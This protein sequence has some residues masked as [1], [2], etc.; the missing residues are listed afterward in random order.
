MAQINPRQSV[1][2]SGQPFYQAALKST[3]IYALATFIARAASFFLFPVYT[4][5]LSPADYGVLELLELSLY[6]WGQL[7]GM[8]VAAAFV[9][10][11]SNAPTREAQRVALASAYW[12]AVLIGAISFGLG[13]V[14]SPWLSALVFGT[15]A[16]AYGFRLAFGAFAATLPTDVAL[17]W[18]RARDRAVHYL[19]FSVV[20]L[21]VSAALAIY[22]L[23]AWRW[24]YKAVLWGNLLASVGLSLGASFYLLGVGGSPWRFRW[25]E[26]GRL[27]SYGVPLGIGGVGMLIVHYGDRFFLRQYVSLDVIGV[28]ALAY[29]LGMLVAYV[30]MPFNI[31]WQ[32]RM[33]AIVKRPDGE[34]IY[35][36][37]LTYLALVL[38]A[39]VVLLSAFARPGLRVLAGR[40]FWQAAD[41]VPFIALA[42][43]VRALG[44][45]V[46]SALLIAGSTTREAAVVW[47]S[48]LVCLA[49]Y[50]LLIPR[51]EVWGAV[52]ATG[53]AFV[54][55]LVLGFWQAQRVRPFA[56][57][58]YR[59][60]LIFLSAVPT[61]L[62]SALI[63]PRSFAEQLWLGGLL[64]LSFPAVLFLARFPTAE[65]QLWLRNVM[66]RIWEKLGRGGASDQVD[67]C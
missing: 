13:W 42:Y 30:H 5:F 50:A 27:A 2:Q 45:Q 3:G 37:V 33:F 4:R 66:M 41:Y 36:R 20:R 21:A 11:W 25:S 56:F 54:T 58:Y 48:T 60:G 47:A 15:S 8:N 39:I 35:S 67:R 57:E 34:A 7:A 23:V 59:I 9:Y 61:I 17:A 24:G 62:G 19:A 18:M 63:Q 1:T 55:L 43:L 46:R 38:T 10:R 49:G 32:A 52:W 28:Y 26:L 53:I 40:E 31:Y 14:V 51:W 6:F 16:Y 29:K 64:V 12:G 65:E 44:A 22:F